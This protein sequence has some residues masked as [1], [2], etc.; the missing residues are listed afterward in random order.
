[1]VFKL[2][3]SSVKKTLDKEDFTFVKNKTFGKKTLCRVFIFTECFFV[4]H[5]AK[6]FFIEC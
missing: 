5:S 3:L 2:Y 6:N 4:T 1:M